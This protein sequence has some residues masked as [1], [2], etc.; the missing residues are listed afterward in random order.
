M[1]TEV[2][3]SAHCVGYDDIWVSNKATLSVEISVK[4]LSIVYLRILRLVV[5][6][7]FRRLKRLLPRNGT[8]L[9]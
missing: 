9:P 4:C 3:R 6:R 7:S 8:V 5:Y 2:V 1:Q